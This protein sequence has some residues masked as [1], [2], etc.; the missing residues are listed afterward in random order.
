MN[1]WF[2]NEYIFSHPFNCTI[3]APTMGGKTHMIK[4][5]LKYKD[6][7]ISPAP[8]NV[9]YCY[10]AWQPSYNDIKLNNNS[11]IFNEGLIEISKLNAKSKNLLILDDLM[12]QCVDNP[13]I[14]SLF[15]IGT[16]HTNTSVFFLTQNIYAKGKYARDLSLN[17][18][19]IINFKN[20][21]DQLQVQVLARQMYG[22]KSRFLIES[23]MDATKKPYGYIFLDLKQETESR[24]RVQTGILP[25]Q[26]RIIYTQI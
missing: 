5:I 17:S 1:K 3:A 9:I 22:D 6:I 19:Y 14:L 25:Y 18:N 4:E 10:K 7:M 11:I 8:T 12:S 21:R 2:V 16:H 26:K 23:F 24:N 20:P 15:T 13:E